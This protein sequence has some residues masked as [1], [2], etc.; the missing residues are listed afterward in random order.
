MGIFEFQWEFSGV[1]SYIVGIAHACGA[2]GGGGGGGRWEERLRELKGRG[3]REEEER[4]WSKHCA[5][6]T[7]MTNFSA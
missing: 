3:R 5:H 2:Q 4:R 1:F 6:S 7:D